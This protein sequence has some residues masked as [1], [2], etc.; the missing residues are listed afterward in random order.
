[1]VGDTK[2]E[3]KRVYSFSRVGSFITC[4]HSF[5]AKY[6][7]GEIGLDNGWSLGGHFSHGVIEKILNGEITADQSA[8][9][10]EKNA[11]NI[12]FPYMT[13]DYTSK[14]IGK[15][16]QFFNGFNGIN[17][18]LLG[19]ERHFVIDIDGISFQGFIDLE[20]RDAKGTKII[21]WK[22]AAIS[23]FS[24]AK[25]KEKSRQLL[26]YSIAHKEKFGDYPKNMYFYLCLDRKPIEVKHT[27]STLEE[28]K[29][30]LKR[31]VEQIESAIEYPKQP[32]HFFCKNLCGISSCE[33][34]G[35][36]KP[37]I[38]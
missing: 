27:Q 26:L 5:K 13:A 15:T 16:I 37:Q 1:M 7:D 19:I 3:E 28:A 4:P 9:Y 30:W 33:F 20:T 23:G 29:D 2:M 21:D 6:I 34:N 24:G 38:K 25:L 8:E 36:H 18:E 14:Y 32:S 11:P 31:G 35:N 17:D 22:F 10:W 12:N